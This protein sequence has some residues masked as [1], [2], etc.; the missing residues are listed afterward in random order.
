MAQMGGIA[1]L[2]QLRG[3]K[4][5]SLGIGQ[6]WIGISWVL[7]LVRVPLLCSGLFGTHLAGLWTSLPE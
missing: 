3:K 6:V 7:N 5:L 1:I 4:H 2:G